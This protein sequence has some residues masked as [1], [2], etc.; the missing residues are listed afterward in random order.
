MTWRISNKSISNCDLK[1]FFDLQDNFDYKS[2]LV[3]CSKIQTIFTSRQK[4]YNSQSPTTDV[5]WIPAWLG[6]RKSTISKR[7]AVN[8]S[9]S[10]TDEREA[11][12]QIIASVNIIYKHVSSKPAS[13]ML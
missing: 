1:S 13:C 6:D 4:N 2:L 12:A 8:T 7:S 5:Q 3:F 11:K 10:L 9:N